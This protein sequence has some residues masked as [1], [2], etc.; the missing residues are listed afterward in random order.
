[1]VRLVNELSLMFI[2]FIYKAFT[3]CGFVYHNEMVKDLS[4]LNP[5]LRRVVGL[6]KEDWD[7]EYEICETI[8]GVNLDLNGD[9]CGSRDYDEN[10]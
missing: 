10:F 8:N 3:C 6:E 1:L 5:A 2:L 9:S 7:R 4:H